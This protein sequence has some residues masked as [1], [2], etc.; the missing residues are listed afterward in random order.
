MNDLSAEHPEK[1]EAMLQLW[2]DY[3]KTNGVILTN[4][5]P[6]AKSEP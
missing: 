6:F 4:D 3:V 5:G 1:V 2:D